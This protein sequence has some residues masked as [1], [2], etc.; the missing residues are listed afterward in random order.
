MCSIYGIMYYKNHPKNYIEEKVKK[1]SSKTIHRGPDGREVKYFENGAIGMNRLS[2]IGPDDKKAMVQ[3]YEDIYSVFNGEIT[4]FKELSE[5]LSINVNCDSEVILPLYNKCGD[6]FVKQLGGMF[7]I[8]M[9]NSGKKS[10]S[11]WRDALG[12]KPL[13]YYSDKDCF[14]FASEI[15]AI[16]AVLDKKPEI[17]NTCIDNIL[18]Y[19]FNPGSQTIFCGIKKV[20]PGQ[21]I[22]VANGEIQ[23]EFYWKLKKNN[24]YKF[25]QENCNTHSNELSDLLQKVIKE[26]SYSD[27]PGG[28]FFSGGLDSSLITAMMFRDFNSNYKVPISIRFLPNSVEDEKYIDMFEIA[29]NQKVEWVDITPE[30]ARQT[31]EE[32]VKYLDEPLENPTHVGTYLMSKR[33]K[34]LGLKTVITG[35]GSDELFIGYKRQE[36]WFKNK[37]PK[38]IYPSLSC[39]IPKEQCNKL[40]NKKFKKLIKNNKCPQ[41]HVDNIDD[42]LILER[43]ERLPEYHNMR[44]DRILKKYIDKQSKGKAKY[45]RQLWAIITL[46]LWL[47]NLENYN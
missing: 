3:E 40:Y 2:I 14:I 36:C 43:G 15:K 25:S 37:K 6:D 30:L 5:D 38:E 12:V 26:N 31:L 20:M 21:K 17:N 45:G 22:T 23:E 46:E 16:Y 33:A 41:E 18:R 24:K 8:A 4:N 9:Y 44:L 13:Y 39:I 19:A 10:I 29:F 28:I 35:D 34:E 11:L 32:L 47:E 27:V 1:M 7:A 42:A